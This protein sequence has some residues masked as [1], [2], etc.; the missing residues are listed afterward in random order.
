MIPD[1]E[2]VLVPRAAGSEG[3]RSTVELVNGLP[4]AWLACITTATDSDV[5]LVPGLARAISYRVAYQDVII[6]G[7][8]RRSFALYRATATAAETRDNA[9]GK[10][11]LQKDFWQASGRKTTD[12]GDFLVGNVTEFRVQFLPSGSNQWQTLQQVGDQLTISRSGAS[13]VVDGALISLP[14]G[15][16]ALEVQITVL[17]GRG[18]L[19]LEDGA[20][21]AAQASERYGRRFSRRTTIFAAPPR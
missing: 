2:A 17:S 9:F 5:S 18:R 1:L 19:L 14:E 7:G 8:P 11:D 16:G 13:A 6:Q 10:A 21:S 3:L 12:L 4:M 20:V 15:I